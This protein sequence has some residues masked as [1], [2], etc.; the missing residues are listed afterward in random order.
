[1]RGTRNSSIALVGLEGLARLC[2]HTRWWQYAIPPFDVMPH[3]SLNVCELPLCESS[4]SSR[5]VCKDTYVAD[6]TFHF[7][8]ICLMVHSLLVL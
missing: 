3:N 5:S 2:G 6:V 8:T 1:M 7:Y 4:C